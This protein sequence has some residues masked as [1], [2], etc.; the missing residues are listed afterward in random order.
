[1]SSIGPTIVTIPAWSMKKKFLESS[2]VNLLGAINDYY[3]CGQ[4]YHGMMYLHQLTGHPTPFAFKP[5][6][7]VSNQPTLEDLHCLDR[8][9]E[10]FLK[11]L[12]SEVASKARNAMV[13]SLINDKVIDPG[14]SFSEAKEKLKMIAG[15][16]EEKRLPFEPAVRRARLSTG[17]IFIEA[18]L[19]EHANSKGY[20]VEVTERCKEEFKNPHDQVSGNHLFKLVADAKKGTDRLLRNQ[21]KWVRLREKKG[22]PASSTGACMEPVAQDL[23]E[24]VRP[25]CCIL[26]SRTHNL[27]VLQETGSRR[28]SGVGASVSRVVGVMF[29]RA[30]MSNPFCPFRHGQ[31]KAT[32][33]IKVII[34]LV[35]TVVTCWFL[36]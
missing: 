24:K 2:K 27:T 33:L 4:S 9:I 16:D 29:A 30:L 13:D 21:S 5:S 36:C 7:G 32:Q 14:S 20:K 19:R 34:V 3:A 23:A 6:G 10:A 31:N 11:S 15:W 12:E 28:I 1:M 22:K 18:V 8:T 25:N 17:R 26:Y 35:R